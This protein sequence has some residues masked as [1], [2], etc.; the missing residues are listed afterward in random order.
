[1]KA[2]NSSKSNNCCRRSRQSR[3]V[4]PTTCKGCRKS[5]SK[6]RSP[7]KHDDC[8]YNK[9]YSRNS[10]GQRKSNVRGEAKCQVAKR[11]QSP[12]YSS[13]FASDDSSPHLSGN[14][15]NDPK[16]LSSKKLMLHAEK[17][18]A[19]YAQ[20]VY[21]ITQDI[22]KKGLYT[23]KEF[24]EVFRRH[25][26]KN[27]AILDKVIMRTINKSLQFSACLFSA[28]SFYVFYL[29]TTNGSMSAISKSVCANSLS[30]QK[31]PI[32]IIPSS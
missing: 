20:F 29:V 5:T 25:L 3:E 28:F 18:E 1:M 22:V 21:D 31:R 19:R 10:S 24:K 32:D 23:D 8:W 17:E 6:S 12:A 14:E 16:H 9:K 4:S 27:A 30:A 11:N 7:C 15:S 26:E 2:S 13:D